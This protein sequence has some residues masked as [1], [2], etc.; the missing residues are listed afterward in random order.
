M[1]NQK[2]CVGLRAA[3]ALFAV[4]LITSSRS[5]AQDTVVYP[6]ESMFQSPPDGNYPYASLISDTAGNL[7]GTTWQGGNDAY[8]SPGCGI[9][10]ELSPPATGGNFWVET[11]LHQF[12]ATGTDGQFPFAGLISDTAGNL[13]GTTTAGGSYGFGTVFELKNPGTVDGEWHEKILHNFNFTNPGK[14]GYGPV[15]SLI[16]DTAGNLYGTTYQGGKFDLGTV[17]ELTPPSTPDAPWPEQILHDFGAANLSGHG[18]FASLKIDAAGNLYG[19]TYG[20]GGN[21]TCT[22]GCGT[23]F[24]L[25]PPS[26]PGAQWHS[27]CLHDFGGLDGASPVAGLTF[28]TDGNLY[29]TTYQG[30]RYGFGTV[31]ELTPPST[32][33]A[34]W[35]W[36]SLHDFDDNGLDGEYPEAGLIF[37]SNG[38]LYGTTFSGGDGT[39]CGGG[40]G[41]V[42][43]LNLTGKTYH[44]TFL[45][46]FNGPTVDGSNP[47]AG[48]VLG[49]DGNLY[50][51]TTVGGGQLCDFCGYGT[52]FEVTP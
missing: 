16:F 18:P 40:C 37:D 6:F 46:A 29:G 36:N 27:Y 11:I 45:S 13:Y 9:V 38:N 52:V 31:F 50:G 14:D 22:E 26:S 49:A 33:G 3:L 28:D 4:A 48:L 42:F 30:G 35:H 44:E 25:T 43:E 19:T 12:G 39:S 10:F 7:Y 24:E 47:Y 15:A 1:Q 51:T 23:V 8:C 17:F 21:T 41:T 20:G 32:L 34:L 2:L 5:A